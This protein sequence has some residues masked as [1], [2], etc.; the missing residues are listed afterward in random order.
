MTL[1]RL[2]TREDVDRAVDSL[3]ATVN[4]LRQMS[5]LYEDYRHGKVASLIDHEK[6]GGS[7]K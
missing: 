6:E 5:P 7:L 3:A 1:G 2:T 4:L